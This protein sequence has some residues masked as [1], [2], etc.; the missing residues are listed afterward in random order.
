MLSS[1]F[2]GLAVAEHHHEEHAH[3]AH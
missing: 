1:L 2:I 3:E